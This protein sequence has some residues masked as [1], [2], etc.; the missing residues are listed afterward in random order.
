MDMAVVGNVCEITAALTKL[1]HLRD[2]VAPANV[3]TRIQSALSAVMST[4][5]VT[6]KD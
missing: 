3:L 5:F 4:Q 2:V 6:A 1:F